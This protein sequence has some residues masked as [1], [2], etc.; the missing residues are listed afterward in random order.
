MNAPAAIDWLAPELAADVL[1]P[2]PAGRPF[3]EGLIVKISKETVHFDGGAICRAAKYAVDYD[4]VDCWLDE[5][6]NNRLYLVQG[7][8][9]A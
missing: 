2:Q 3:V 1:R 7:W 6:T 5:V 9:I 8:A 4:D